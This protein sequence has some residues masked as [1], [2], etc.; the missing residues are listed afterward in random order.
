V[1]Q[2]AF[3]VELINGAKME[4]IATIVRQGFKVDIR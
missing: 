4:E 3:G 1:L 2:V